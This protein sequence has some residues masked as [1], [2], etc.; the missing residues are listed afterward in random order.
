MKAEREVVSKHIDALMQEADRK[1]L[2]ADNVGRLL[3]QAAIEIWLQNR[4]P[5]DIASELEFTAENIDPD[6][7]YEFIRP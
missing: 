7:D 6:A 4:S 1:S 3:L 5:D 2:I